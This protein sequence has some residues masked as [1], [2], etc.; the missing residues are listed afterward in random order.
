MKKK[1]IILFLLSL[2]V[3]S[4]CTQNDKYKNTEEMGSS[5]RLLLSLVSMYNKPKPS[6]TSSTQSGLKYIT[7]M[8]RKN[9]DH[10][11]ISNAK[12][13][14]SYNGLIQTTYSNSSGLTSLYADYAHS[15][16]ILS[17]TVTGY[18]SSSASYNHGAGSCSNYT[19]PTTYSCSTTQ[20]IVGLQASP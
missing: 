18:Q 17:M 8:V 6:S 20:L 3:F 2:F 14:Y 1:I 15:D 16:V 9:S 11:P 12:I 7:V 5:K 13:D 19:N 4:N 10:S